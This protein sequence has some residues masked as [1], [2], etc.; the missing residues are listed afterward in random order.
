[1][2]YRIFGKTNWKVS[3]VGLG[4]WVLGAGWRYVSESG[5]RDRRNCSLS[6]VKRKILRLLPEFR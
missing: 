1:M 3:E 2:K 6:N 5:D 4:T